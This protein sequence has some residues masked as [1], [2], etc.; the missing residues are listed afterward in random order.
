MQRTTQSSI[1][2]IA[3][4]L[5]YV[6][7]IVHFI[8]LSARNISSVNDVFHAFSVDV[9]PSGFQWNR[10]RRSHDREYLAGRIAVSE[11]LP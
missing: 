5:D 7:I 11:R 2:S 6:D 1:S 8:V 9:E 3:P 4:E 10:L